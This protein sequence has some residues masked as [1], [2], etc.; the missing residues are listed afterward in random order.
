MYERQDITVIIPIWGSYVRYLPRVLERLYKEGINK[1]QILVVANDDTTHKLTELR[2]LYSDT[3]LSIGAC[4]NL[5]LKEVTTPLA[6][7]AD[8]D[9]LISEGAIEELLCLAN[10]YP[11][12]LIYTGFVKRED[13]SDYP[14]PPRSAARLSGLRRTLSQWAYNHL[15]MTTG[16]LI[17]T[18]ALKRCGGF[19]DANLAEDGMLGCLLTSIGEA[20]FTERVTRIYATH[21]EGLCQRGCSKKEWREAYRTQRAYLAHHPLTPRYLRLITP[22]YAPIHFYLGASLSK[23]VRYDY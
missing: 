11:E 6:L 19:P 22:L 15:S 7:F 14:W 20:V 3:H 9:D 18:D 21:P 10:N 2:V 16:T 12:A 5:G 23:K 4:R 17:K 1:S 13:G 8:A